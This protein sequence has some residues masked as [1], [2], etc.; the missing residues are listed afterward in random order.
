MSLPSAPGKMEESE[1]EMLNVLINVERSLA[2]ISL[3]NSCNL[4]FL[5]PIVK[6]MI[7]C[8]VTKK[9]R[10]RIMKI[11]DE[12]IMKKTPG[13]LYAIQIDTASENISTYINESDA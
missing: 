2:G 7:Q 11:I 6:E 9:V 12:K 5:L 8:L 13:V 10:I 4:S 3:I 1:L